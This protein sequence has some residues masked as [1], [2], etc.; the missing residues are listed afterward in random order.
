MVNSMDLEMK[1]KRETSQQLERELGFKKIVVV[2]RLKCVYN[3]KRKMLEEAWLFSK[4]ID[5]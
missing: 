4:E 2:E 1:E 3:V 5:R